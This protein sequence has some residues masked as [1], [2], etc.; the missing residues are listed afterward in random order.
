MNLD[1]IK[2]SLSNKIGKKV[3]ITEKGMRNRKQIFEG[4][5]YRLYPNIFSI[6]TRSGEKTFS[7]ADIATKMILIKY[8]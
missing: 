2:G 7:Y 5:I 8:Q 4:T 3:I 6:M 1:I